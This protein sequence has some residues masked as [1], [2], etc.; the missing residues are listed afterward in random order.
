M[1]NWKKLQINGIFGILISISGKPKSCSAILVAVVNTY[2]WV[3]HHISIRDTTDSCTHT[4][5]YN[6][7]TN[8]NNN[9]NTHTISMSGICH[10]VFM[11]VINKIMGGA[12]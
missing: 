7:N 6:N 3:Q 8:N 11:S 9:M 4:F 5:Y 2:K 10:F 1:P 12:S